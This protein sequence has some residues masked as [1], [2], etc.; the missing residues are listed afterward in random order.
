MRASP[1]AMARLLSVVS[2]SVPAVAMP[3]TKVWKPA[4]A[5]AWMAITEAMAPLPPPPAQLGSPSVTRRM[6]LGLVLVRI[7]K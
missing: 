3:T 2:A 4:A 1:P 7:F 5:A 6:Y